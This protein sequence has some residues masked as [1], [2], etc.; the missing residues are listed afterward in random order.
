MPY[1]A[2]VDIGNNTTE[3]AIADL[4]PGGDVQVVSSSIVKT[5]GIKGTLRN[6]LGVI[7][8]LDRA[9][10]PLSVPRKDLQR[11]FLNEATPVIGDVA[12]ETITE[13]VITESAMIGHN[14]STPGGLGLG[15]GTTV[16]LEE[17]PRASSDGQWI[18]VIH[19][20]V[21]FQAAAGQLNR[22][23]E[24]NLQIAGAIVQ[25]DD[26]VLIHNRLNRPIPIVDE[27]Q[28][29]D[30]IPLGMP[31]SIEVAPVGKTI[32]KLSNPYDIA[33]LFELTPDETRSIVPIARALTGT[34]SAVVI[35]TPS[36][37]IRQRRIPAGKL[38]LIGKQLKAEVEVEEGAEPIMEKVARVAPLVEIQAD[39]GTNVG[40]MIETVRKVMADL[41]DQPVSAIRV[42]DILAVDT[43]VPQKVLGSLAGEYSLGN[44]VGLAAMVE[45]N[46]MPMQRLARKLEEEIE[47]P[48]RV[49]GVEAEMAIL[50]ALTT[51]GTSP[52]LAILDLGGGSTDAS[53]IKESGEIRST[54]LAGAG[55][56]VTLLINKELD[57]EDSVLA[58]QIKFFPLAKVES[59][60]NMRHENGSV[61]FFPEPLDPRLFGRVV[62]IT[63]NGPVAVETREPLEKIVK[64]RQNAKKKV[65][66]QNALRALKQV[67][68]ANNIR[69]ISFLTMVGGSALDFEIPKMISDA[70]VEY[71]V[72][73][74]R[75]N[76]RGKEG[77]RNAVA[78]GLVLAHAENKKG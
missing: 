31:A 40:G 14:P 39:A 63:D 57:L 1:I 26:G 47:V 56:M 3:V 68:P 35:K 25:K 18:V 12:M 71:G 43:L 11:V 5:V 33:T 44:A 42:Q 70:L 4:G 74:G 32:E 13:T 6:V 49:G 67:A 62:V 38:T 37:D 69:L 30:R 59:L 65:F 48:V 53:L 51:P 19:G 72:V 61:Q 24:R 77:P 9:L 73:T 34:R 55:D 60:F 76:V 8:A 75:A 78:T 64:V 52:P 36:G 29:I 21:E 58:E 16:A 46:K 15:V 45:T 27:V 7:D 66:V 41:T 17:L 28:H 50:G 54:H 10:E 2:G 22:A 20:D 23:F